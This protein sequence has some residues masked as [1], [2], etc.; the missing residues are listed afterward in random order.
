MKSSEKLVAG[1]VVGRWTLLESPRTTKDKILCRCECGN[2][3]RRVYDSVARGLSSQCMQCA[4]KDRRTTHGDSRCNNHEATR[5]YRIWKKIKERCHSV[6]HPSYDGYGSR[7]ISMC[8]Q[9]RD[10]YMVFR[11]WSLANGYT[12]ELTIDRIENDGNYEPGNCRW[13]TMVEQARNTRRTVRAEAFGEIKSLPEW[14]E[15]ER[16]VVPC[17]TLA[18]RLRKGVRCEVALQAPLGSRNLSKLI[19]DAKCD[20]NEGDD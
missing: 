19:N 11:E 12:D 9:W 7:G 1:S 20:R 10:S 2:V 3:H 14:A 18:Y 15:D 5:L 4:Q 6:S 16:C 13:A 8:D 17:G